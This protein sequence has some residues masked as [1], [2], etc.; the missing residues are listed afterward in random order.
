[1]GLMPTTEDHQQTWKWNAQQYYILH[2]LAIHSI[3]GLN[4]DVTPDTG[5]AGQIQNDS[6]HC[7]SYIVV[8]TLNQHHI[9]ASSY[10]FSMG[11]E[12]AFTIVK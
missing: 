8:D 12:Y 10:W 11:D 7:N 5:G 4:V 6:A 3:K 1:M 2:L 9:I